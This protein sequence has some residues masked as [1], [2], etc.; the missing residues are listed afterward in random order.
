[1]NFSYKSTDIEYVESLIRTTDFKA[2]HWVVKRTYSWMNRFRR[3]LTRW[4]RKVE[5]YEAML[6]F[7]CCIIVWNKIPLGYTINTDIIK[8]TTTVLKN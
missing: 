7:T 4:E 6:Y 1:M 2:H 3:I 5:N 8:E